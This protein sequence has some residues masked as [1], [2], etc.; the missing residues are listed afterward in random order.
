MI[1]MPISKHVELDKAIKIDIEIYEEID[2]ILN[3]QLKVLFVLSGYIEMMV[4]GSIILIRTG[5]IF[6]LNKSDLI[7]VIRAEENKT[8]TVS[9]LNNEYQQEFPSFI[10]NRPL[11]MVYKKEG[12]NLI[13]KC[14]ASLYVEI[15]HPTDG[16][17]YIAEGYTKRLIGLLY[18]YLQTTTV[19]DEKLDVQS[20]SDKVKEIVTYIH[21]NYTKKLTLDKIADRLYS[22]KYYLS[23]SFRKELGITIGN[24]IQEVR[25]FHSVRMLNSTNKKVVTIALS[26]GFPNVRSFN[27][28]FKMRYN[29]T[30]TEFRE[31]N[32]MQSQESDLNETLPQD[33][34]T[35]LSPYVSIS[36]FFDMSLNNSKSI[37]QQVD[38]QKTIT[39]YTKINHVLK[40]KAEHI[41]NRLQKVRQRLNIKWVAVTRIL[42]KT[43]VQYKGGKLSCS[44]NELDRILQQIV[45]VG[46]IPYL[47]FHTIDFD[48]WQEV[49]LGN[50]NTF[51][52]IFI[53][54]SDH[55]R[56]NYANSN[57]W[58]YEFR[59]FYEF[60]NKGEL[61]QPLVHAISIFKGYKNILIHFP[62]TPE[63]T[64]PMDVNIQNSVYCI[65]DLTYIRKIPLD[66]ALDQ[67]FD[68]K[69][70]QLISKNKNFKGQDSILNK[71]LAFEKDDYLHKY[72]DL[73]Q[74]NAFVW[75]YMSF[76]KQ[77]GDMS[78]YF[79]PLSL[80]SEKLFEY[81]PEELSLKLSLCTPDG[82]LKENWYAT[83]FM[84]RLF[85]EVV[86]LSDTCIITKWQD[87]YRILTIYPEEELLFLIDQKKEDTK[88][89]WNKAK[90]PFID[91]T[92]ELIN[93]QGN[94][95]LIKQE[96]IPE[97]IDKR[98]DIEKLKKCKILSFE[99]VV[100][101][102]SV[103]RPSRT[104]E[105]VNLKG[106][107]K[108][109]FE[110]PLFGIVMIDLEK[111]NY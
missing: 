111:V 12:Y 45:S 67:L 16:S 84:N 78:S 104:V 18:R 42:K 108:L 109:Q 72:L 1:F 48:D 98:F 56:T 83:E 4:N 10:I 30:P 55:L 29:L 25:L 28:A 21:A 39:H 96:L 20:M 80:G 99:D 90:S 106:S 14:I 22:S 9:F 50:P 52:Q 37:K 32:L 23:H 58:C 94:Y 17:V 24:Y 2:F 65:D 60:T 110:V 35:L 34:L 76:M 103:N 89:S 92:L 82:R 13:S 47:Q 11:S 71:V 31:K 102:N 26:N 41:D 64:V 19:K 43:E 49:G 57:E 87:N 51:Q 8:L 105:T 36:D 77:S 54:L 91:V 6:I 79:T 53:Q 86:F 100:Y 33:I 68:E 7:R 61:C 3:P 93:I 38:V 59:C 40:V 62:T 81:F 44:F 75:Q 66:S 107:Y 95:R 46:M 73:A 27:T 63:D 70:I 97:L 15:T 74:A 5:D 101:W 88:A 85:E 69:H